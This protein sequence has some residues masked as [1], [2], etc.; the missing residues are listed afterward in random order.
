MKPSPTQA[1]ALLAAPHRPTR[2]ELV[3]VAIL[4]LVGAGL[5]IAHPSRMAVE[6][7]DEGVYA[8]NVWFDAEDGFRYPAQHLYAPPLLPA[9]IEGVFL[10]F[11]PSNFGAMLPSLVAGCLTIPLVWWVGREWFGP[12]AGVASATLAAFSDAH[13]VFS[14]TAL[15]DVLLC[16]WLLLAVF[17]VWKA[18]ADG[19]RWATVAAG[20][21]T[22]LAWWT[23]YNGWLPLAIGGAGMVPWCLLSR[24]KG[25]A[26]A[27]PMFRWLAIAGI[28][29][30]AWSPWLWSLQSMGGYSAV[31]TNHRGYLVGMAGWAVACQTQFANLTDLE[32]TAGQHAPLAAFLVTTIWFACGSQRFTWNSLAGSLDSWVALVLMAVL[33]AALRGWGLTACVGVIGLVGAFVSARAIEE[34]IM[35][36]RVQLAIWML[37]VWVVGMSFATPLYTPY[38]RLTLPWVVAGWLAGGLGFYLFASFLGQVA[39]GNYASATGFFERFI[40]RRSSS[41]VPRGVLLFGTFGLGLMGMYTL[42]TTAYQQGSPGWESRIAVKDE[43]ANLI[44]L[45]RSK[46]PADRSDENPF[47]IYTFAEPALLFQLRLAG[48][49]FVRP[50]SSLAMASPDAPIPQLKSFVS[51]GT[52]AIRTKGFEEDFETAIQ[53]LKLVN[54]GCLDPS[55]VVRLDGRAWTR[56]EQEEDSRPCRYPI[57]LYRIH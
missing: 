20:L 24:G 7:F 49:E 38:P 31:A 32:G 46:L 17:F 13:I 1:N 57:S 34:P 9:L 16:F 37:T 56:S 55:N 11:G 47:V 15:T 45:C 33:S 29:F 28:A 54:S 10:L 25:S 14:R 6:H 18:L 26:I 50:V 3:I 21:F 35:R 36:R 41:P 42:E 52:Q 19:G 53:R 2:V 4:F 48:A 43:A 5:R 27:T 22:A 23:K 51:I 12:A 39:V 40:L 30:A 44:P 8:S